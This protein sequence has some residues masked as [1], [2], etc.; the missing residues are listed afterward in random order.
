ME[1]LAGHGHLARLGINLLDLAMTN[2]DALALEAL[3]R[4]LDALGVT[5]SDHQP[6]ERRREQMLTLAVHEHDAMLAW[7]ALP[8]L[9]RSNK[10]ADPPPRMTTVLGARIRTPTSCRPT[11][12]SW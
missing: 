1:R 6:Q 4:A 7:Q 8:Q 10:T 9:S 2:L 5:Q 12:S 3:E 11:G